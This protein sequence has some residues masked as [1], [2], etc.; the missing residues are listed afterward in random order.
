MK[1]IPVLVATR[2]EI[3][4]MKDAH[5]SDNDQC[6]AEVLPSSTST[7]LNTD[8]RRASKDWSRRKKTRVEHAAGGQTGSLDVR[9]NNS[10]EVGILTGKLAVSEGGARK[11]E[12]RWRNQ[13]AA[14]EFIKTLNSMTG[15][16]SEE[17]FGEGGVRDV[18]EEGGIIPL[19]A[20]HA[21]N[22]EGGFDEMNYNTKRNIKKRAKRKSSKTK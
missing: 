18:H 20:V 8:T 12:E 22:A 10:E 9:V 6:S 17:S 15:F 21:L 11:H 5:T 3:V 4:S 14:E 2:S 1:T 19:K 13:L 16:R 7:G